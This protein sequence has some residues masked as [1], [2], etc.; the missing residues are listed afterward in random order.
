MSDKNQYITLNSG[1]KMPIMGIGTFLADDEDKLYKAI[2]HAVLEV[3]YVHID[4]A[5][6][7]GNEHVV[8]KALQECFSK[9]VKREDLFITTKIWKS[10][11]ND[12]EGALKKSLERLQLDYI[13][14]YLIHFTVPDIDWD[15]KKILTPPMHKVW[16]NMEKMVDQGLTKNIGVSNAVCQMWIDLLAGAKIPPALN[17]IENNPLF[18]QHEFTKFMKEYGCN[19][20]C[21]APIGGSKQFADGGSREDEDIKKIAEKHSATPAQVCLAW[22]MQRGHIVIP[23]STTPERIEENFKSLDVK[24]DDDDMEKINKL[25]TGKRN[26]DTINFDIPEMNWKPCPFFY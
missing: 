14:M 21:Y 6:I 2:T 9:G 8:G 23:K 4:T 20:T 17:Q 15:N 7:Y 19:I 22:N 3:G 26:F 13:D 1:S 5:E 12:V 10:K 24:L 18:A 11:M 16:E 25:D